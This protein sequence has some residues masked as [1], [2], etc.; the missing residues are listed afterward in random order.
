MGVRARLILTF[1]LVSVLPLTAVTLYSYVA[2]VGA[3]RAAVANESGRMARGS[4]AATRHG[5][6]GSRRR[7]GRLWEPAAATAAGGAKAAAEVPVEV[8]VAERM[9]SLLGDSATLLDRVEFRPMDGGPE[10]RPPHTAQVPAPPPPP[11]PGVHRPH[12]LPV[13]AGPHPRLLHRPSSSTCGK[14][15]RMSRRRRPRKVCRQK[16]RRTSASS[17][18][19]SVPPSRPGSRSQSRPRSRCGGRVAGAPGAGPR[20]R[21]AGARACRNRSASRSRGGSVGSAGD[22]PRRDGRQRERSAEPAAHVCPGARER[23][24]LAR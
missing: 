19:S 13:P 8:R 16:L 14:S 12:R 7:V 6:G 15:W 5:N 22:A 20:T 4:P 2:S 10:S 1:L 18:I 21:C 3:F 24:S 9:A 23:A 11:E 17:A